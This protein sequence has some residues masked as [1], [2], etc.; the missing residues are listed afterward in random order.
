MF[1]KTT[2]EKLKKPAVFFLTPAI[3]VLSTQPIWSIMKQTQTTITPKPRINLMP[4]FL[5]KGTGCN[6]TGFTLTITLQMYLT[7]EIEK[8][9]GSNPTSSQKT[10]SA[11]VAGVASSIVACPTD[12]IMS[13]K[14]SPVEGGK[15][16]LFKSLPATMVQEGACS[17]FFLVVAPFL[18]RVLAPKIDNQSALTFVSG[19]IAGA[20]AGILSQPANTIRT[21][22]QKS[23][24]P[25]GFFKTGQDIY[26]QRG[27]PGLFQGTT[28]R[29][30]M[31]GASM[32]VMTFVKRGIE[33]AFDNCDKVSACTY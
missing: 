2:R 22:Q 24:S 11:L 7:D 18:E 3:E 12:A 14:Q 23:I 27:I 6:F 19:S 20:G 5:Y 31:I 25:D 29:L 30:L 17:T 21:I 26:L 10:I 1:D 4:S 28:S 33:D 16:R 32:G 8:K 9:F 13:W 15:L